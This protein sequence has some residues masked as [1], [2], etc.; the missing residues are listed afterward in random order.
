MASNEPEA[1]TLRSWQDAFRGPVIGS[2]RLEQ[3]LRGDVSANKD[4]LRTLV[5]Q[6]VQMHEHIQDAESRLG[7]VGQNC[8]TRAI[9][10]AKLQ[11]AQTQDASVQQN[12]EDRVQAGQLALLERCK[13]IA[14][15]LL[16][17]RESLSLAAR[18]LTIS[19]L[20]HKTLSQSNSQPPV[21]ESLRSRIATLRRHL[22]DR[23][24]Q[25]FML[26][27]A[28]LGQL[29]DAMCAFCLVTNSSS[30][31]VLSH[32]QKLR[33][34]KIRHQG[35]SS[36]SSSGSR[37]ALRLWIETLRTSKDLTG[38]QLSD[39]FN[40]L[41][42]RP[43]IEDPEILRLEGL[44]LSVFHRWMSPEV[45][46]FTPWVKIVSLSA[47][48]KKKIL[49][50]WSLH[51]FEE[52][53]KL[54]QHELNASD[55][56]ENVLALRNDLLN[57][58]LPVW[59]ST[60]SHSASKVLLDLRNIL[61]KGLTSHLRRQI[62]T[63]EVVERR[64]LSALEI[65]DGS[66][67]PTS[68]LLWENKFARSPLNDG[69]DAFAREL[70]QRHTG[71]SAQTK[72]ILEDLRRWVDLVRGNYATLET[73]KQ[74]KWIDTVEE[75]D[76]DDETLIQDFETQLQ[77]DDPQ[78]F[79]QALNSGIEQ[80]LVQFQSKVSEDMQSRI[81]L[82]QPTNILRLLRGICDL[83]GPVFPEADLKRLRSVIPRI[84]KQLANHVLNDIKSLKFRQGQN[85]F[86]QSLW[87]DDPPLPVI[88]SP[89]TV[90]LLRQLV[91]CMGQYGQDLWSTSAVETLKE[92]AWASILEGDP[93]RLGSADLLTN[94]VH[95]KNEHSGG[96]ELTNGISATRQ[97]NTTNVQNLQEFFDLLYLEAALAPRNTSSAHN[98]KDGNSLAKWQTRL[99]IDDE[100]SAKLEEKATAY[101]KRTNLLFGYL[102]P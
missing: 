48:E 22:L 102:S 68:K 9:D 66:T 45:R 26:N 43:I 5:G 94:G 12:Q 69:A 100:S 36:K 62:A 80:A 74:T 92:E 7:R 70:I 17:R 87:D 25:Q 1:Q 50:D 27:D 21:L 97:N 3:Q 77:Q 90:L 51:A 15:K 24:D 85:S 89:S 96:H 30:M 42:K 59:S 32:F 83:L 6:I 58:W 64:I 91:K 35:I 39:S 93:L 10:A 31:D 37:S 33:L 46:N 75:E 28:S 8:N 40:N 73:L 29:I 79:M 101:W 2:R 55:G 53:L 57:T 34:E 63:L 82:S 56:V 23:V 14:S 44:N 98:S 60:P 47:E 11:L 81:R 76:D 52:L 38:R 95:E 86:K 67:S 99:L 41:R 54:L 88:P 49:E 4:R 84:H 61:N 78:I 72:E 13:S 19:R 71:Q 65:H 18:L 20:I 16:K